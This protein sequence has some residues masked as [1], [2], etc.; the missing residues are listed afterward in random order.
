M[1]FGARILRAASSEEGSGSKILASGSHKSGNL[2][3][4]PPAEKREMN[5]H[6]L[7]A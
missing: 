5:A 6:G 2:S 7:E 1:E 4:K 3:G